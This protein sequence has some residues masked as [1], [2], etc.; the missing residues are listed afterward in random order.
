MSSCASESVY[1][2]VCAQHTCILIRKCMSVDQFKLH[3]RRMFLQIIWTFD[4]HS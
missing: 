4:D 1:V 3:S 2:Y